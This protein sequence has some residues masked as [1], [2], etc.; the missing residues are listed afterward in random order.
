MRVALAVAVLL[1]L[2]A[3]ARGGARARRDSPGEGAEPAASEDFL[4]RHFQSFSDLFT[5]ELPQRLRA[6]E[7]RAQA[8]QYLDRA[9]KQ[10]EPL[11]REL[12]SNVLGLFSSLLHLGKSDGQGDSP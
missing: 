3:T 5:R 10:L 6:E 7:L 11:A 4:T 2:V 12:R 9:N 8:E 1:A